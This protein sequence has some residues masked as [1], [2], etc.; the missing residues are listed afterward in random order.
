MCSGTVKAILHF[1][2]LYKLA[3]LR[4]GGATV[5]LH[6]AL[7]PWIGSA[8]YQPLDGA[9]KAAD[10]RESHVH[11][12]TTL[13]LSSAAWCLTCFQGMDVDRYGVQGRPQA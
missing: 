12:L 1:N 11:G 10:A 3:S 7:C 2:A 4:T 5:C 13:Q 9:I 8:F 6:V